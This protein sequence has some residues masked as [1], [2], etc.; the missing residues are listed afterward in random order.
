M[1]YFVL[2]TNIFIGFFFFFFSKFKRKLTSLYY[3]LLYIKFL[4]KKWDGIKLFDN[5]FLLKKC[6][7]T[8]KGTYKTNK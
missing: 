2:N 5:F 8:L 3:K 6:I 1:Y 4:F 7:K